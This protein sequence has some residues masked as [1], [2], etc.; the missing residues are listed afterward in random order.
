MYVGVRDFGRHLDVN[1]FL[2]VKPSSLKKGL[3]ELLTEG[4]DPAAL[5]FHLDIFDQ[6]DLRGY[7]TVVH[8][9]CVRSAVEQL[10]EGI[11]E[12]PMNFDWCARGFSRI[13]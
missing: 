10:L 8:G 3:S 6:Q 13:W 1:W 5:S 4:K 9:F 2:S 11:G 12:N 7:V